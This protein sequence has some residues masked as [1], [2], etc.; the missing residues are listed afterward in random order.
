MIPNSAELVNVSVS[1][2]E[3]FFAVTRATISPNLRC[4]QDIEAEFLQFVIRKSSGY[5]KI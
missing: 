2:K 4:S 3:V 1:E 5:L